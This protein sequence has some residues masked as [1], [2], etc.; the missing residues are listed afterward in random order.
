MSVVGNYTWPKRKP[1]EAT[2]RPA[3]RYRFL[4]W[5]GGSIVVLGLVGVGVAWA[6]G[7]FD[8]DPRLAE[9]DDIQKKLADPSVGDLMKLPV[10]LQLRSVM[11]KLSES[12]RRAVQARLMEFGKREMQKRFDDFFALSPADR[13]AALKAQVLRQQQME[14][15]MSL[16]GA[17][18]GGGSQGGNSNA[19]G[20]PGGP[21][22]KGGATDSQRMSGMQRMIENSPPQLRAA[23]GV[24]H[25]LLAQTGPSDGRLAEDG[26]GDS[27]QVEGLRRA[28]IHRFRRL[29]SA[30]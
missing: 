30:S 11:N 9:I 10:M 29:P 13:E 21:G 12:D 15:M 14:A 26:L 24:Y 6:L 3:R 22:R 23:F 19:G 5:I 18:K 25:Q 27:R 16:V 20:P 1:P 2:E 17:G 28:I 4:W 7:A 8:R